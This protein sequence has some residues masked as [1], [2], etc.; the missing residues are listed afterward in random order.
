MLWTTLNYLPSLRTAFEIVLAI[1]ALLFVLAVII[2]ARHRRKLRDRK[3]FEPR[4]EHP[5]SVAAGRQAAG[6]REPLRRVDVP[7]T[8]PSGGYGASSA[9]KESRLSES[10][11]EAALIQVEQLRAAG[12]H[13]A[14][15]AMLA[16]LHGKAPAASQ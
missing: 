16:S 6:E 2:G 5:S 7:G 13:A 3:L 9:A 4:I 12:D 1:P 8:P 14:A 10:D 11:F 15:E